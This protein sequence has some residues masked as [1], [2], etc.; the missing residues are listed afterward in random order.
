MIKLILAALLAVLML[1][2]ITVWSQDPPAQEPPQVQ[3]PPTSGNPEHIQPTEFCAPHN[4]PD[5]KIPC[6]CLH[7][8]PNGCREGKMDTEMRNCNSY[9][10]KESC[11][12][13]SS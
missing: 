13:C 11:K 4:A 8:E 6:Q 12:C 1:V 3:E 5:G 2:N 9:C 7:N 10:W